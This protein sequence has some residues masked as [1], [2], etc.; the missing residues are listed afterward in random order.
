MLRL[1]DDLEGCLL[2]INNRDLQTFKVDLANTQDIMDSAAGQ[3][4][5]GRGGAGQVGRGRGG[6]VGGMSSA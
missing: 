1:G 3:Q 2:G 4:V 6:G 5:G